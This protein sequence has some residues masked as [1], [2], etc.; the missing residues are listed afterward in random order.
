MSAM[1]LVSLPLARAPPMEASTME[2]RMPM[3]ATT[4]STS[5]SVKP[6]LRGC[7]LFSVLCSL[8]RT[9]Y[10]P[11]GHPLLSYEHVPKQTYGQLAAPAF[12]ALVEVATPVLSTH[13]ILGEASV[14]PES[15]ASTAHSSASSLQ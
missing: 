7:S 1:R 6:R 2:A 10:H 11:H 5:M 4:T 8:I 9:S 14:L 15:G 13:H 3:I 12:T